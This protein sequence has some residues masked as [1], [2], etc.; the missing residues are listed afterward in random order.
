M[1]R[2]D[3]D[4]PLARNIAQPLDLRSKGAH[5]EWREECPQNAIGEIVEHI[6][7]LAAIAPYDTI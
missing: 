4:W 1:V 2:G 5:Q 7:N 6:P 3:D